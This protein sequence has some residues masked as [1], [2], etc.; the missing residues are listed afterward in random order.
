MYKECFAF[1]CLWVGTY[2]N[3]PPELGYIIVVGAEEL[4]KPADG[5]LTA[6][7][8]RLV[9][10]KILVVFV[11][12]VIGQVHVQLTLLRGQGSSY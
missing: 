7:V 5:P 8:R 6:F 10:L 2:G 3:I 9:S 4:C 11:Y 1:V 12:R